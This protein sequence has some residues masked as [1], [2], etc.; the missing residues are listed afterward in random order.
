MLLLGRLANFASLDLAR[1]RKARKP[2][3]SAKKPGQSPPNFPGLVPS[4]GRVTVPTGFSPPRDASPQ[5]EDP[6]DAD[7]DESTAAANR[8]WEAIQKAFETFHASLGPDFNPMGPE[9]IGPPQQTA[10]G[11]ALMYRTYSIAGIWMSYFMGLIVLHRAHPSMPPVAMIAAGM[12]AQ[13]T[14]RYANEI[15]RIA[16]GLAED[17]DRMTEVS[18]SL[19]SA[20]I[21]SCFCVFVAGVQVRSDKI[22]KQILV[23]SCLTLFVFGFMASRS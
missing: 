16:A 5:S 21:E 6:E 9:E 4:N 7:I 1:K 17:C 3:P 11:P 14:G 2:D 22:T 23:L 18:T 12:A 20:F 15:G 8:E 13:H 19:G 10:F